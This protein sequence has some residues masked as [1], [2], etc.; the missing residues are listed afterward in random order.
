MIKLVLMDGCYFISAITGFYWM[1]FHIYNNSCYF[2]ETA[3]WLSLL[4]CT[5]ITYIVAHFEGPYQ[6]STWT[7]WTSCNGTCVNAGGIGQSVR[8]RYCDDGRF[9]VKVHLCQVPYV[10]NVGALVFRRDAKH[11]ERSDAINLNDGLTAYETKTCHV[12][13]AM[14][15]KC[16]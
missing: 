3:F 7:D 2:S 1:I 16:T 9:Y 13:C 11:V 5:K 14:H 6:W 10:G 15:G 4:K 12:T 8:T